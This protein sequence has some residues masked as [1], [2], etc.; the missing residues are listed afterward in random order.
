MCVC[1]CVYE[2]TRAYARFERTVGGCVN[3]GVSGIWCVGDSGAGG[4]SAMGN[5]GAGELRAV[6]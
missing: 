2:L 4:A 3:G 5:D 1:L 6:T